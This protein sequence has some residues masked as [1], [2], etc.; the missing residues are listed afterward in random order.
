MMISFTAKAMSKYNQ[1]MKKYPHFYNQ[2]SYSNVV[3]RYSVNLHSNYGVLKE[4]DLEKA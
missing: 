4:V 1:E 3:I 2:Y